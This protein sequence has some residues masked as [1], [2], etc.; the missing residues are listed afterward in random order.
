MEA[1]FGLGEYFVLMLLCP[2]VAGLLLSVVDEPPSYMHAVELVWL[3]VA[4]TLWSGGDDG[5]S[6]SSGA[7][8][9]ATDNNTPQCAIPSE[10]LS[11]GRLGASVAWQWLH[12]LW[13]IITRFVP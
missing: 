1:V 8:I 10:D 7:L 3:L 11:L 5:W 13:C 9:A 12:T 4:I 6:S 2:T